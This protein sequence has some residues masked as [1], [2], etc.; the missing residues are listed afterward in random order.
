MYIC[1]LKEFLFNYLI[2]K[3]PVVLMHYA[4]M[5]SLELSIDSN[6]ELPQMI[7][8]MYIR[9]GAILLWGWGRGTTK[10]TRQSALL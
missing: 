10:I 4:I 5:A 2:L 7:F 6:V 8:Y 1:Q 9:S 3:H